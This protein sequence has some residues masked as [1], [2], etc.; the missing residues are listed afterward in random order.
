MFCFQFLVKTSVRKQIAGLKTCILQGVARFGT[1][2]IEKQGRNDGI[3]FG[4]IHVPFI[5]S[6]FSH[7]AS[8]VYADDMRGGG[9]RELAGDFGD[10]SFLLYT[11]KQRVCFQM[12]FHAFPAKCVDVKKNDF[13]ILLRQSIEDRFRQRTARFGPKQFFYGFR[14]VGKTKIPVK[15][16]GEMAAEF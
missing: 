1:G 6:A 7:R 12:P 4:V 14:N 5:N 13:V 16:F 15:G 9:R 8:A 11:P 10:H 2:K 3:E